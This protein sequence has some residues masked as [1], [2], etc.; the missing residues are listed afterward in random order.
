MRRRKR[1]SRR[2]AAQEV[3]LLRVNFDMPLDSNLIRPAIQAGKAR[4]WS[5]WLKSDKLNAWTSAELQKCHSEVKQEDDEQESIVQQILQ[6]STD[7]LRR[8]IVPVGGQGG[9]TL[10][11]LSSLSAE[12]QHLVGLDK[13]GRQWQE[14]RRSSATGSARCAAASAIGGTRMECCLKRT[15]RTSARRMFFRAHATPQGV[16]V[17]IS[18]WEVTVLRVSKSKQSKLKQK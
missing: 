3:D 7:F 17:R 4:D 13:A 9:V 14:R 11:S 10:S 18:S 1:C 12:K 2:Q 15:V 5:E 16:C 8:I 6:K